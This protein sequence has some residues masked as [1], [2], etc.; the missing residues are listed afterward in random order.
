MAIYRL[1]DTIVAP[2]TPPGRGGVAM[3]R[4]SGPLAAKVAAHVF[5]SLPDQ[6]QIRH[7]YYGRFTHGDDGLCILFAEGAS[8]TNESTAEF[9]IHGSPESVRQ[10]L[11]ACESAGARMADRGEF[12]MRAVLNGALDLA[13]AEGILATVNADTKG[14]LRVAN[15]LREGR[16]SAELR[17]ISDS[18]RHSL[19][20]LEALTDFSEELGEIPNTQ[21]LQGIT[22]AERAIDRFLVTEPLARRYREGALIVIAGQPNAGKSSL[23]NALLKQERAIVTGIPGTTRD[24]IEEQGSIGGIPVRLVDTAGLRDS[25]DPVERIGIERTRT[26]IEQADVVL[27]L[28]DSARGW[29]SIDDDLIAAVRDSAII[30]AGKSDLVAT[31]SDKGISVSALTGDGLADLLRAIEGQINAGGDLPPT[32]FD[33]HYSVLR[34]VRHLLADAREA[35]ENPALPDDLA[36]VTLRAAMRHLGELTG[37]TASADVLEQIFS[38]FCIGK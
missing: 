19:T 37:D 13:Q 17:A 10:L 23:L 30:V 14:Q 18:I 29:D 36:A 21:K 35:I 5:P 28:F 25:D 1:T 38:Q 22:E 12:S 16:A 27:Y 11:L 6:P 31:E 24:T 32:L 4:V 26:A 2:I 33:R 3:I 9:S 20:T 8:F 7:A 34:E 15:E